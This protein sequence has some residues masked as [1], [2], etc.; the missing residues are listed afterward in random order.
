MLFRSSPGG[1]GLHVCVCV[2]YLSWDLF[3]LFSFLLFFFSFF[4]LF[5]LATLRS[6]Q[7]LSSPDK[8]WPGPQRWE[9]RVQDSGPPENC[10]SQGILI[11]MCSPGGINLINKTQL[12]PTACRL[13]CWTP[14]TK[15]PARQEHSPTH[16]QR[17]CLKSK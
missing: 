1:H 17:G 8:G 10:W 13:Q 7:T 12:H 3:A 15:Q 14:C 16:Q 6:L 9:S 11:S 2:C 5:S 4:F